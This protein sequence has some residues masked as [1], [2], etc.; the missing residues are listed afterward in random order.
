MSIK[1][2]IGQTF[3]SIRDEFKQFDR[4]DKILDIISLTGVILFLISFISVYISGKFNAI[5]IVFILYP[6]AVAGLA[7]TFR[8]KKREKPETI[9]TLFKE[10]VS[11]FITLTVIVIIVIIITIIIS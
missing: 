1:E 4:S 10:W 6:M 8:M 2:N 9:P 5:N 3:R 11:I 7:I